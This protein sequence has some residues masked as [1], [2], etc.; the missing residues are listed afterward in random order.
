[1]RINESICP[2]FWLMFSVPYVRIDR[3]KVVNNLALRFGLIYSF[4]NPIADSLAR[5]ACVSLMRLSMCFENCASWVSSKPSSLNWPT[6]V[7]VWPY[8]WMLDV[9]LP[10]D[11][12]IV[13]ETLISRPLFR[14]I[15]STLDVSILM[16]FSLFAICVVSSA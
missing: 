4:V 8:I 6:R 11:M 5:A 14:Q 3:I 2:A 15:S 10:F 9:K 12:K 16:S 13:F 1:M 7:T